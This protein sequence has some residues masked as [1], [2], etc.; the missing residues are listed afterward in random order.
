MP[1]LS[2]QIYNF[3]KALTKHA[4]DG[5]QNVDEE[6]YKA[7]ITV[8]ETCPLRKKNRCSL[9]GCFLSEKALWASEDCPEDK[10]EI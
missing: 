3:A 10:W 9:C 2:K 1:P 7:R 8:C 4:V 6:T 5:W